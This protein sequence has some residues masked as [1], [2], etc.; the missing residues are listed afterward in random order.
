VVNAG[1]ASDPRGAVAIGRDVCLDGAGTEQV[2]QRLK[3]RALIFGTSCQGPAA[4]IR[5][6]ARSIARP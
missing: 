4:F 1:I 6:I 3:Q 2:P 5:S